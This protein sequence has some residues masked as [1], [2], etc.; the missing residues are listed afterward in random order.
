[1]HGILIF[2]LIYH[3]SWDCLSLLNMSFFKVVFMA[4]QMDSL[5]KLIPVCFINVL[6]WEH[7]HYFPL[8]AL[9]NNDVM[10]IFIG[11]PKPS[12]KIICLGHIVRSRCYGS[13]ALLVF[14]AFIRC[15]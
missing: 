4:D 2:T 15:C 10:N 7:L 3:Y 9:I 12:S 11:W 8:F 1:M 13:K 14:E 6:M 5:D